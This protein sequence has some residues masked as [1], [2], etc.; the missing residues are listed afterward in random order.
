MAGNDPL[1][2]ARENGP[3]LVQGP[4]KFVNAQGNEELIDRPWIALC[5]CGGSKQKPF[6]DGTHSSAGFRAE[7]GEFYKP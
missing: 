7:K 4:L 3:Y 1:I 2:E 6:C 5:R